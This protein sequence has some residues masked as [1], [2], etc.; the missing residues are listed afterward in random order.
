MQLFA[1]SVEQVFGGNVIKEGDETPLGFKFRNEDGSTTDLT[2]SNVSLK[3]ANYQGVVLEKTVTVNADNS[4]TFYL[5]KDDVTGH[6]NMRLEFTVTYTDGSK[7]KFPANGWQEIKITPTLD[8]LNVGGVAVVTVEEIKAEYQRQIDTFKYEVNTTISNINDATLNANNAAG[9]ANDQGDYAKTQ[10]DNASSKATELEQRVDA[11]IATTTDSAEVIDAR[12]SFPVLSQRL[13]ATDTK[14]SK[15]DKTKQALNQGVNIINA[16]EA[17]PLDFKVEGNTL[18]S[19]GNSKIEN[20]KSYVLTD[21]KTKVRVIDKTV[22]GVNKFQLATVT[23]STDFVGK[24]SGSMVENPHIVKS[25][26]QTTLASPSQFTYELTNGEINLINSLNGS[27]APTP[28]DSG[29]SGQISQ[30]LFS[31]N[32]IEY[33]E[34]KY[35]RTIVGSTTA[36]KVAWL[37]ER[38]TKLTANWHG[39]GSSPTGNKSSFRVW[40]NGT[41]HTSILTNTSSTVSKISYVMGTAFNEGAIQ[42]DGFIHFISYAE[43]SDGVTAST[44]NTDYISLDVEIDPSVKPVLIRTTNFEEKVSGSTV[45]NAHVFKRGE[46]ASLISPSGAWIAENSTSEY[47]LISKL[48][49]QYFSKPNSV[50]G[51]YSQVL[52]SFNLIEEVERK[53][54]V[55]P[56]TDKVAWLKANINKLTCNW[57]GFGSSVGGNKAS[58]VIWEVNNNNWSAYVK[59]HSSNTVTKIQREETAAAKDRIDANG[60][61]HF[62]SYSEPSDGTTASTINTDYVELEIELIP[63]ANLHAPKVPLY[64]V[65]TEEYTNILTTW[66]ESDVIRRY[67]S[68][69]GMQHLQ[70]PIVTVE[71]DNLLPAFYEWSLHANAKVLSP[72]ESVIDATGSNQYNDYRLKV[73]PS[74]TYTFSMLHN[75]NFDL[76]MFNSSGANY[77]NQTAN[78]ALQSY[79]FTT[80]ATD[81]EMIIRVKSTSTGKFTFTNPML[82]L[83]STAKPFVPRNPSHLYAEVKLGKIGTSKDTLYQENGRWKVRKEVE[84]DIILDG[85]LGWVFSVDYTGF[86]RAYI[87]LPNSDDY[88]GVV[89]KYDCSNLFNQGS[90]SSSTKGDSFLVWN[91]DK[92]FITISDTDTGFAETYTPTNDEVKAYFNG[93]KVKTVDANNKPTAWTNIVT[94]ADAPTQTLAYVSTTRATG[95]TPYKLSY[96]LATPQV[97]DVTDKVEGALTV[98]GLT[99]LTL[100]SGVIVREKVVP[101]QSS[102][103]KNWYFNSGANGYELSRFK[104]KTKVIINVYA[105]ILDITKKGLISSEKQYS[106]GEQRFILRDADYDPTA[107]YYVTYLVLDKHKFTNNPINTRALY[108]T[109]LKSSFDDL[110]NKVGDIET[111]TSVNI[112]AIAELYKRVKALGG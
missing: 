81:T 89:T 85:S 39:F 7:E 64:E 25:R 96:V 109:S 72:Y 27:V 100:D 32:L 10:G 73:L 14:L 76:L 30:H 107:N 90:N 80:S 84:K 83:G 59:S 97:V 91:D 98:N 93:W 95:Y 17:T 36:E 5:S 68:V 62:L 63:N 4:I 53:L 87:N 8:N 65:T 22:Q 57:W 104:Q 33:I 29:V 46:N 26:K 24:V 9:Y 78:N 74:T 28:S 16:S 35:G 108:S 50:N 11:A 102:T 3:I 51:N 45:E 49:G 66:L 43:P 52:F 79:T 58:L 20:G 41:W 71:G 31:F 54:G 37:K 42:S 21:K 38:I 6:G 99:Q 40:H 112:R 82:T 19:L 1:N 67:P 101:V 44:I 70:H 23:G 47:S 34:R 75:G 103:D 105:E 88:K 86:K 2:G 61:V 13:N 111:N 12:G 69:E 56:T 15:Q 48:D 60:F 110:V 55:I 18:V 94:G 92:L 106:Y 77:R